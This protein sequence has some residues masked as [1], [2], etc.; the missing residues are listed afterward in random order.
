MKKIIKPKINI[1]VIL[2]D[3]YFFQTVF[4]GYYDEAE[5]NYIGKNFNLGKDIVKKCVGIH[6]LY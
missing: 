2:E 4:N 6:F 1:C 5:K 3:G